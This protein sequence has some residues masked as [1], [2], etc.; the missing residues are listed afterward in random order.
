MNK[1]FVYIFLSFIG[2]SFSAQSQSVNNTINDSSNILPI[3]QPCP[4]FLSRDSIPRIK[5]PDS[6]G[7]KLAKGRIGVSFFLNNNGTLK[8]FEIFYINL[9]NRRTGNKIAY[10]Y[11]VDSINKK[12]VRAN[13]F[14][15]ELKKYRNF[16]SNVMKNIHFQRR[17]DADTALHCYYMVGFFIK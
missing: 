12:E 3:L 17:K 8:N 15:K 1:L 6:L 10:Y 9:I 14:S 4:F 13:T 7:G 2:I 16:I 11:S 5:L